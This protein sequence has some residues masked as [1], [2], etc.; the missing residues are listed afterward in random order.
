MNAKDLSEVIRNYFQI[1]AISVAAVWTTYV[2]Y[3]KEAP[4][5]EQRTNI[6]N[7]LDVQVGFLPST[8]RALFNVILENVGVRAFDVEKVRIRAWALDP[9]KMPTRYYDFTTELTPEN[10]ITDKAYLD[11]EPAVEF[12]YPLV[13]HYPAGTGHHHTFVWEFPKLPIR[14][15]YARVDI[16]QNK[17]EDRAPWYVVRVEPMDCDKGRK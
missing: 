10:L 7:S 12:P 17:D 9:E 11:T 14:V 1:I 15:L 4:L 8:C 16:F 2:F 13:G 6:T 5:L 3:G